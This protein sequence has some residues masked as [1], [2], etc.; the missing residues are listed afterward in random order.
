MK[1][2][3]LLLTFLVGALMSQQ[4]NA[5]SD[6]G[7]KRLGATL[8]YVS[9]ED[10]DGTIGFGAFADLGTITPNIG[11]EA[12]LDYWSQSEEAFGTKASVHD[13]TVGAR[14]KYLFQLKDSSIRPFAGTGVSVHFLNAEVTISQPGFPDM[15]ESDSATKLGLDLGGG[16]ATRLSDQVDFHAE[17]WYIV[18][19]IDQL[20]LR[21]GLSMKLGS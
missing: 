10:L 15:K 19:D 14:G 6:I 18:S 1:V 17:A 13:I 20:S 16:M 9:P 2:K 3:I 11:L 8:A 21:M 7:F 12:R 4:A 5:Q